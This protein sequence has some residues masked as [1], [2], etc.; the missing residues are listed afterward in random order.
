MGSQSNRWQ[1]GRSVFSA[2]AVPAASGYNQPMAYIYSVFEGRE[3]RNIPMKVYPSGLER[4]PDGRL[5]ITWSD[6]A[7]RVYTIQQ[8]RNACPCAVCREKRTTAVLNA[9]IMPDISG[10]DELRP[11]TLSGMVPVGNYAYSLAFSD[12]HDTGIYTFDLLRELGEQVE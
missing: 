8:L 6:D 11:L 4:L 3:H 5:R 12:G 10:P 7:A 2:I 9:T 1:V